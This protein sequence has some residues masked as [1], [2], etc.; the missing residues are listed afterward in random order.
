M[1]PV[2]IIT[3]VG[4]ILGVFGLLVE[5]TWVFWIGVALCAL[6]LFMNIGSGT[7][8]LP[9]LPLLFMTAGAVT[10]SPWYVGVGTGLVLW[11]ALESA[12][13]L[14]MLVWSKLRRA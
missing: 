3:A 14:L 2:L 13:E 9:V 8:K 5:L 4:P 6:V 10:M 1:N 11:T 12:G 7:M